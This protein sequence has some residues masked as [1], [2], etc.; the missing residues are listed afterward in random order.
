MKLNPRYQKN[1][2]CLSKQLGLLIDL[3]NKKLL[4]NKIIF[5]GPKGVGKSTLAYHLINY[6]F[7]NVID[8]IFKV[9]RYVKF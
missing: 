4:L 8:F 9:I 7:S 6:I 1:L 2:Y 5:S 3:Y